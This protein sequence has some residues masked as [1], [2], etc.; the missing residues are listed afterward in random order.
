MS[1]NYYFKDMKLVEAKEQLETSLKEIF[2]TDLLFIAKAVI[3]TAEQIL[4]DTGMLHIGQCAYNTLLLERQDKFYRSVSEMKEFYLRN[5][6]RLMIVAEHGYL[7]ESWEQ[8]EQEVLSDPPRPG[9]Q[10]DA[11]GFAWVDYSFE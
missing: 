9:I 11:E 6:D 2:S 7:Y 5:Q 3:P 10:K 8:F 1:V 4:K